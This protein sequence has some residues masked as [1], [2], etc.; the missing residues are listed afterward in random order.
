M[1]SLPPDRKKN[2][3]RK[4]YNFKFQNLGQCAS[5]SQ[6]VIEVFFEFIFFLKFRMGKRLFFGRL[7]FPNDQTPLEV[8]RI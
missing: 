2:R 8:S 3:I 1:T 4:K 6:W 7:G 5:N